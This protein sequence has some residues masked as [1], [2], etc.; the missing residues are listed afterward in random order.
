MGK[1]LIA[2]EESQVVCKAFRNLGQ[3]AYSCD[4][5]KCSGGHPEWHIRDDVLEHLEGWDLIIAHPPCTYLCNSGVQWLHKRP[6]RWE[7]LKEAVDFF[8]KMLNAPCFRVAVEN[9]IMH[10]YARERIPAPTQYIQP[11]W[12]GDAVSKRTGF[13]LRN[14]PQL[15][16]TRLITKDK[17]V[18]KIWREPPGP[19]RTR[20]RSKTFEGVAKAMAEQWSKL[21]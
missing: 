14:L 5:Q 1:V 15:I 19:E 10:K 8:L 4:I 7:K 12:F 20:I 21:L 9:P 13:W 16:P 6:G 17:V 18:Q 3:E 11:Y 2:C